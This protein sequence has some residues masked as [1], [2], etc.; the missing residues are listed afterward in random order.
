MSISTIPLTEPCKKELLRIVK[1]VT[2]KELD[3]LLKTE[4][5]FS[6]GGFRSQKPALLRKRLEQLVSG[7]GA[8]SSQIRA[9]LAA[10]ART[11][12]LL[13]HLSARTLIHGSA[14]W[15]ALLGEHV[16]LVSALLDSRQE[17][18]EQ[19]ELWMERTPHFLTM[20]PAQALAEIVEIFSDLIALVG[21]QPG[22]NIP[23]TKESWHEQRERLEQ[24]VR[25]LQSENRRLKGIDDKNNRTNEMLKKEIEKNDTLA[26]KLKSAETQL[27]QACRELET[28]TAELQRETS[29]REERLQAALEISLAQEFHGWLTQARDLESAVLHPNSAHDAV[30]FAESA[31][32]KQAQIDRH[33]RN[34]LE[35][36][37]RLQQL[38]E[39]IATVHATLQNAIHRSPELKQ[40]EERLAQEINQIEGL[41]G[42]GQ[43]SAAPMEEALINRI[44]AAPD[45]ALPRLRALPKL[46]KELKILNTDSLN[47][48]EA[49]FTRRLSAIAAI[50]VPPDPER[51]RRTDAA[52]LLGRALAG[53]VP[54][55]LLLD[56]HNVIFGLPA[57]YMPGRGKSVTDAQK[58]Q[59]LVD[60]LIRITAPNPALR[61]ILLFDGP[62][63]S[64]ATPAP[65]VSVTYSGGEGEHRADKVLIDK[66][67]FLKGAYPEANL[68]L[69]SNDNDLCREARRL[70]AQNL[71]VL[72]FGGYL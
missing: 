33:S 22:Q 7:G 28:T 57:R 54:A 61:A 21:A 37:A 26:L 29:R 46:L 51:E 16:F 32:K 45:E 62:T 47:R 13:S 25:A 66:I 60:D 23:V 39:L 35:L 10:H 49:E 31:L 65:N 1:F 58:R 30:V 41:I 69:V 48:V 15:A 38:Q 44:H 11:N 42:A 27:R 14:A 12:S 8:V 68:L 59:N 40:A 6:V 19:A 55:I 67:R 36:T 9:T 50:G 52:S 71:S 4:P 64:D 17:L 20:E 18:R 3:T 70:G 24:R 5:M 53:Q 72:D 56:G 2:D 34:R 43:A 63:R